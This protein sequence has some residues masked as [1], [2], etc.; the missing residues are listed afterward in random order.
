MNRET[1]RHFSEIPEIDIKRSKFKIPFDHKTTFNAGEL[2]PFY[3]AEVLPG[4]TCSIDLSTVIRMSTPLYPIMDNAICDVT[5]FFIPNRIVWNHW[6]NFWGETDYAWWDSSVEYEIPQITT[7]LNHT[8]QAKSVADYMGLPTGIAGLSVSALPFRCYAKV[9]G[10]WWRDENLQQAPAL[11]LTDSNSQTDSTAEKGG[12]LLKANKTHDYFTSSLPYPQRGPDTLLPLGTYAPVYAGTTDISATLLKNPLKFHTTDSAQLPRENNPFFAKRVATNFETAEAY[13][14]NNDVTASSSLH[15]L[16]PANL[17]ADLTRATSATISQL[18]MAFSLQ[19]FYEAMARGGNRYIE[20]V[21]NIFGVTSPDARLQRSEYLGGKRFS[22]NVNQVLQ[23]SSTDSTSPQGNTGAYS[24]TADVGKYF[25][26]S[27]TEHGYII[28]LMCVREDE[29]T[30]GQGIEA[31]WS[32]KKWY[33][34]YTPQLA[35]ISEQPVY[36]KEIYAQGTSEDNEVFAYQ[37]AWASGYRY[38]PNICSGAMRT[39]YAQSLDAWHYADHYTQLPVLGNTWIQEDKSNF[40]RTLA[41]TSEVENQFIADI[42]VDTTWVRPMPV[43]SIPGL[44]SYL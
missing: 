11:T 19:T 22:I 44:G 32:R 23:T 3:V 8:F 29:H 38:K 9:W 31:M 42:F 33:D 28:G 20:F 5:F 7:A 1:E 12:T 10:D 39:T 24:H 36:N 40:D 16:T 30:Y 13:S 18:R 15:P 14:S 34:F 37:E 35:F 21:K 26:K 2:I 17:F 41:V 4:D 6:K 27:F 43:Y 25:T